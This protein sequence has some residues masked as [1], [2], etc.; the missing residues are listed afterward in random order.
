M[1]TF[2]IDEQEYELKLTFESVKRLNKAFDGGSLEI[3]GLAMAGDLDAFPSVLHAGLL[4]T[5][6]KFTQKKINEA[7][8]QAFEKEELSFDDIQKIMNEV[9]TNSFFYRPTVQKLI[10]KNPEIQTA[11]DN[12]LG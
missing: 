12:L 9:V 8:E 2:T 11:L 10:A 6:E 5:G 1:A 4:H 7:I 3:I